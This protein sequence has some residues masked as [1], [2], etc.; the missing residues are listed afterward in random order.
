MKILWVKSDLLHPTTKGG[1]IRTLEMLKRM[2]RRHE[3]HYAGFEN[4]PTG[5]GVRRSI[6]YCSRLYYLPHRAPKRT[7]PAFAAQL[8]KGVFSKL[9]VAVFRYRSEA[10]ASLLA[11]IIASERFDRIVCDFITPAI[12]FPTLG[13]CVVFQ[14]NV[15]TMIW[16]RH[17][18][19]AGNPAA[20]AYL[21]LQAR[22][23]FNYEKAVCNQAKHVIAVSKEDA[24]LMLEMFNVHNVSPIPTG[25]DV[26]TFTP[27]V[28]AS[29][30]ESSSRL[31]FVGSMDWLPNIDGVRFF[32]ESILPLIRQRRPDCAFTIVGREPSREMRALA[33]R[34][35]LI[36]VTGTVPDVRPHLWESA[37]SVVPLRIGGGTR[38]K[39]YEAMAARVPVVSTTVGAEGLD[40]HPP[41][42]VRIADTPADFAAQCVELLDNPAARMRQA[43]LAWDLVS[44]HFGW[45]GI[46]R[47][48]E[49]ILES[50]G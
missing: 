34:D 37:I 16:R 7:S 47:Q 31:V 48:F 46:A 6:E 35:P 2:H 39:I 30:T 1:H 27:A 18:G 12:N 10:M 43:D 23:M 41:Q 44:R 8:V 40:V 33:E 42:D 32:C 50:Y 19:N 13:S 25:V 9:P 49:S 3:I 5:E 29:Q 11:G 17:A 28:E 38:M 45:D 20:K 14:H 22:R 24:G 26:E 36:E 15:E 4:D 21:N